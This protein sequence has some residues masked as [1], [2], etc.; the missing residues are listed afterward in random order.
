MPSP[1]SPAVQ[2]KSAHDIFN[3]LRAKFLE[4]MPVEQREAYR[5]FG[6]K[7]HSSFDVQTGS[8]IDLST[9]N[10]EESLAYIV[11]SLKSGLHPK[12]LTGDEIHLLRAGYGDEWYKQ[13]DYALEDL[14]PSAREPAKAGTR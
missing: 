2:T 4:Q 10:M 14:P 12:Y 13:W 8:P 3:A 9:I 1:P 5:A 6:E 7:F 11:E